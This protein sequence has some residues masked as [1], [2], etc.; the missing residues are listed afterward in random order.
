MPRSGLSVKHRYKFDRRYNLWVRGL[1]RH[2]IQAGL[3][4]P[5]LFGP[6]NL[7][8]LWSF[9]QHCKIIADRNEQLTAGRSKGVVV[10]GVLW[11]PNEIHC[12]GAGAMGS[13]WEPFA[14]TFEQNEASN[15][16]GTPTQT[17]RH[18]RHSTSYI[19]GLLCA[20]PTS[21]LS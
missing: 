1:A 2:P 3:K 12:S 10:I 18:S 6:Q 8:Y 9:S 7:F 17:L 21:D 4:F 13:G 20:L 11:C 16:N 15:T 5:P 14:H 19:L